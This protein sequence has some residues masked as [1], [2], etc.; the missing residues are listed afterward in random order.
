MK[1]VVYR[2]PHQ[3]AV[4]EVE[5]PQIQ[6]PRDIILKV[7]T[8]AICGSDLH[9]YEGRTAAKPGLIMGHE[10]MGV[11]QKLGD[12]VKLL[13]KGDRVVLPFNIGCGMCKYCNKG[14]SNACLIANPQ[15]V[16]AGY[17][18]V[19]LGPYNGGQAEFVRVPFADFNALKLPGEPFD[20]FEDDFILLAD[21][22]PTGWHSLTLGH[23]KPGGIVVIYGAGP[24]GLL[25]AESAFIR[26]ATMVFVVDCYEDRLDLAKKIGA[27]P[28]NFKQSSS[29]DH[30]K[31]IIK[32]KLLLQQAQQPGEEK[33]TGILCGVDAV[34][35]EAMDEENPSQQEPHEV[36][37]KLAKLVDPGGGIGIIGV[38]LPQDPGGIDEKAKMGKHLIPLGTIWNKGLKIG[39]GQTPVKRY[40]RQLRDLIIAGKAKPSFIVSHHISVDEAP[41]AYKQFDTRGNGYTKVLIQFK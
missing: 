8:A 6:D 22:L 24:V 26:G 14:L 4:E 7:T 16:G 32:E 3:M 21:I 20:K 37:D 10:I 12:D 33:I 35:Y 39:T 41:D 11:V 30:I 1:A 40:N 34:G 15:G 9:M 31:M 2:G 27:I 28:I 18:Y 23:F 29:V 19:G 38:F 13:K 25:A 36:I 5:N 17:G